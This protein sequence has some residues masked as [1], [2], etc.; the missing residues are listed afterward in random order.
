MPSRVDAGVVANLDRLVGLRHEARSLS[1]LPRQAKQSLL[2]GQR[3]SKL[4]GRGLDFE[5]LRS[6]VAGDDVRSIDWRVT[7]RTSQAF[8]RVYRE[9]RDRP[10]LLVVDQRPTMFFG[11]EARM[12]SVA[13]AELAALVG[14]RTLAQGDRVGALIFGADKTWALRPERSARSVHRI[15]EA[16]VEASTLLVDPS[17]APPR[18]ATEAIDAAARLAGHDSLVVIISDLRDL[19]D[20]AEEAFARIRLHNDLILVWVHD[21]LEQELPDVG[22]ARVSDG[23]REQSLFTNDANFR[24][25]FRAEFA[26][27]RQR[28]QSFARGPHSIGFELGA[29]DDVVDRLRQVLGH[30][31]RAG[32][33]SGEGS[34]HGGSP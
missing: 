7:A 24:A 27:E 18:D 6:Y 19:S 20:E 32:D 13:A 1:F 2:S 28:F 21:R 15:C 10:V 25:R 4:R 23:Y 34:P 17:S 3:S 8:V 14:W 29:N 22:P 9:E 12:K 31:P 33:A 26:S 16:L 5:E 30:A 11:S